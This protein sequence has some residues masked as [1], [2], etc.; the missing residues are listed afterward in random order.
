MDPRK[1]FA[2]K[3]F[4]DWPTDSCSCFSVFLKLPGVQ[5][6]LRETWGLISI[7]RFPLKGQILVSTMGNLFYVV[8]VSIIFVVIHLQWSCEQPSKLSSMEICIRWT[9]V[10]QKCRFLWE[11][12]GTS[13]KRCPC[14]AY[15]NFCRVKLL[16]SLDRGGSSRNGDPPNNGNP[17]HQDLAASG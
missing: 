10:F 3:A 6:F 5:S 14:F 2:S 9:S 13:Q 16:A 4:P 8:E 17:L 12:M 7:F 11:T 1:N 15:I